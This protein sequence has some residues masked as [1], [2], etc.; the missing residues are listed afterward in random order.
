FEEDGALWFKSQEMGDDKNRVLRR[1]T[2]ETTY[3]A[4]DLAYHQNK[5]ERGYD[6]L[7]DIWGTDHHGY[8]NR[9]KMALKAMGFPVDSKL[10]III[11]QLVSLYRGKEQ[12]RMSKRTGEMIT[13]EEVI[14]EIGKDAVRLFLTMVSVNSHLDFDLELAKE[15]APDNPVYYV[16]YAHARICSIFKEARLKK[17]KVKSAGAHGRVSLHL[18]IDPSELRLM[19]ALIDLPDVILTAAVR[20]EPHKLVE[21]AKGLA[22]IFHNFYHQCRVISDDKELTQARLALVAATRIALHNVLKLLKVS[23]PERM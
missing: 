2:G 17:V 14:D 11:G 23:A 12:V 9:M 20:K 5:F 19:R 6:N 8:V 21:Y 15:Q 16:Q 7:I 4:A 10:Q 3:F 18:L 22:S 13:L 1:A